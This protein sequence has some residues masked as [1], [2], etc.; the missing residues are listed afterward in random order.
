LKDLQSIRLLGSLT[1]ADAISGFGRAVLN[2]VLTQ[3][4]NDFFSAIQGS[5]IINA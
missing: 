2:G 5:S 3:G 4:S 1:I